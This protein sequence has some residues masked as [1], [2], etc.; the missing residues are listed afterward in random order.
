[1]KDLQ[2]CLDAVRALPDR[3]PR[4]VDGT[5]ERFLKPWGG[6]VT[7]EDVARET[8]GAFGLLMADL[9]SRRRHRAVARARQAAFHLARRLT[10]HSLAEIGRFFGGRD[11]S[12]VLLACRKIA[13][14][15]AKDP[16][17]ARAVERIEK[18]LGRWGTERPTANHQQPTN[19][20]TTTTN[21]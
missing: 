8:A 13:G 9:S 10:R 11:H 14:D 3:S 12:T 17:L 7:L 6:A 15:T 20:Q 1:M 4:A 18:S 21:G 16:E 2:A 5:I 19:G